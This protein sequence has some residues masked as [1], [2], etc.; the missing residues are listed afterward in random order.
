[1]TLDVGP[2]LYNLGLLGLFLH[3]ILPI[4]VVLFLFVIGWLLLNRFLKN[5]TGR[6]EFSANRDW[7]LV[8]VCVIL[9]MLLISTVG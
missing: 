1:M 2:N 5:Y 9:I 3:Y 7:V 4:V 6:L 8:A